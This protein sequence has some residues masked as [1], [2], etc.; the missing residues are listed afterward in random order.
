MKAVE[1]EDKIK[2]LYNCQSSGK[3]IQQY[4]KDENIP[5]HTFLYWRKKIN[6]KDTPKPSGFIALQ[7]KPS[8]YKESK[9][10]E[11]FFSNGNRVVLYDLPGAL[12]IKQLAG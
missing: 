2:M 4:C 5:Y 12:F 3:S 10:A 8:F 11:V 1:L 7:S 6:K 9:V